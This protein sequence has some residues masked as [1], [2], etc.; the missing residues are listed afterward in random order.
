MLAIDAKE[1]FGWTDA[2]YEKIDKMFNTYKSFF[3]ISLDNL[4]SK[5]KNKDTD[6]D[7]S[8]SVN[9]LKYMMPDISDIV[10]NTA[11]ETEG[12]SE[13]VQEI[14]Y[15]LISEIEIVY[16]E[17]NPEKSTFNTV[18]DI[19]I[20]KG[21]SLSTMVNS[22]LEEAYILDRYWKPIFDSNEDDDKKYNPYPSDDSGSGSG[23]DS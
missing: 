10:Y 8:K 21:M 9:W 3:N 15:E 1:A 17:N 12:I 7:I 20:D 16:D 14:I 13:T 19:Y 4:I 5:I 2:E 11:Y 22:L 6:N 23:D 18:L